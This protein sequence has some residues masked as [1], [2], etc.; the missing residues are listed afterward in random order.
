M[1]YTTGLYNQVQQEVL[2]IKY[3]TWLC[4]L[5]RKKKKGFTKQIMDLLVWPDWILIGLG[6]LYADPIKFTGS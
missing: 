5:L 3:F 4:L 2:K 6:K 1:A